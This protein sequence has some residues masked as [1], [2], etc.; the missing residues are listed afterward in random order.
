MCNE[1][2]CVSPEG[3][4]RWVPPGW[5]RWHG[6]PQSRQPVQPQLLCAAMPEVCLPPPVPKGAPE[7]L[8]G[9]S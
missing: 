4:A 5:G 7:K 3:A 6:A 1:L 2:C 9:D 8:E